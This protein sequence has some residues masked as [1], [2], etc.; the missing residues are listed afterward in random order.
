AAPAT[1]SLFAGDGPLVVSALKPADEGGGAIVH[2]YNPTG[3]EHEASVPGERC[4][5]DET[6]VDGDGS[7]G[8]FAIAAWRILPDGGPPA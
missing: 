2:A 7:L 3:Q 6:P 1:M 4:R 5:L 8:P